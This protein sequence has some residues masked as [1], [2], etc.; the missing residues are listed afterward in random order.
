MLPQ[1]PS[2]DNFD[3]PPSAPPRSPAARFGHP[4]RL[5]RRHHPL[6]QAGLA[7]DVE[8]P[9]T[10]QRPPLMTG[11]AAFSHRLLSPTSPPA[12]P[13]GA[14]DPATL[15]STSPTPPGS[16]SHPVP[17]RRQVRRHRGRAA[18]SPARA[19]PDRTLLRSAGAS[20]PAGTAASSPPDLSQ[21]ELRVAP[22]LR[23][24]IPP[25]EYAKPKPDLHTD[26]AIRI[27]G[28]TF[29]VDKYGLNFPLHLRLQ[30]GPPTRT[31]GRQAR[32][33]LRPLPAPARTSCRPP[34]SRSPA[35]SDPL[36]L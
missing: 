8:L 29:L 17:G 30:G 31:P 33:L 4:H 5:L 27:F 25:A 16:S 15:T 2:D 35:S 26:R 14:G 34:S 18:A 9:S 28:H 3:N 7:N 12:T 21:I 32:Q 11:W 1:P 24:P 19:P 22:P 13:A 10:P 6:P 20:V 36:L 23:R